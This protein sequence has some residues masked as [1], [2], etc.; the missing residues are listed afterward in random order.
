MIV[1]K[2]G[3]AAMAGPFGKSFVRSVPALWR[4]HRPTRYIPFF[5]R[6]LSGAKRVCGVIMQTVDSQTYWKNWSFGVVH[7][8]GVEPLTC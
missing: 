5:A 2:I 7:P 8:R 3:S 4:G 1:K 6:H